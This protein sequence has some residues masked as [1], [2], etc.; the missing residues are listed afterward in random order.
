MTAREWLARVFR[1]TARPTGPC[2]ECIHFENFDEEDH[3][4]YCAHP[5]HST[6]RSE[7]SDYGGHWTHEQA[8]CDMWEPAPAAPRPEEPQP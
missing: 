2:I 7:H 8:S 6:W 5:F 3:V 4:G 1:R